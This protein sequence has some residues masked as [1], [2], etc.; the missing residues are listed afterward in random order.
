M[1]YKRWGICDINIRKRDK[2]GDGKSAAG[3]IYWKI[4]YKSLARV[5]IEG[6]QAGYVNKENIRS[7]R[8]REI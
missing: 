1:Q 2:S 4:K 6:Y 8:A 7:E 5:T 3:P